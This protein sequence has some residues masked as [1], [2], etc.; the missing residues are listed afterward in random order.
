MTFKPQVNP[1][2]GSV[3]GESEV[4]V[5]DNSTVL[6][7]DG[8]ELAYV[9]SAAAEK[10]LLVYTNTTNNF[11]HGFKNKTEF[12]KFTAGL[13]IPEGMFTNELKRVPEPKQN[14]FSTIKKKLLWLQNKFNTD[15]IEI[16]IS[17]VDNF[18]DFLPLPK[19]ID[20]AKSGRYKGLRDPEA[21]PLLLADVKEYLIQYWNAQVVDGIEADDKLC[22]RVY[23]GYQARQ[24]K[25]IGLTQDK[26]RLGNVGYW[27][28]HLNDDDGKG[29]P[30]L[31][32]GLG[33]LWLDTS[34]KTPKY[35]GYGRKWL[36]WQWGIG[37]PVDS[38]NPRD[39]ATQL[40][41]K[42]KRFGEKT[43]FDLLEPLR[44]DKDCFQAIHDLYVSWYG[45]D[46]FK[47]VSWDDVEHEV[48]YIDIMQMYMD[49][50]RMRRWD[51]D[52][53]DVRNMLKKMGIIE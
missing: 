34:K 15:N 53:I 44:S 26:D 32:E 28:D 8:D 30:Q 51:G 38:Y 2:F 41:I 3:G 23:E 18:R 12:A 11:E 25:V 27:Y 5:R 45:K 13:T 21:K 33:K 1:Q 36:Y 48:D 43:L 14:A 24:G 9:H 35:T 22:M 39:I 6:V 52:L 10:Q 37:D 20:P 46:K 16:Y 47:Y 42:L 29:V 31:I 40:G 4:K 7:I 19:H 49:C 50:A 17:G